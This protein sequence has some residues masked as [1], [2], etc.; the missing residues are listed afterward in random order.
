VS[1]VRL[2]VDIY[3]PD[4]LSSLLLELHHY[5]SDI[6]SHA[7]RAKAKGEASEPVEI[8]PHLAALVRGSGADE[9]DITQLE[10]LYKTLS[11]VLKTAPV[12]HLTLAAMPGRTLK[13]Q[14]TVW[15]RTQIHP[16]SMLT[17]TTRSD[18]GGGIMLHAGSHFYDYSFRA[19][20][21]ANSKRIGELAGV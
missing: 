9:K 13:R 5:I 1:E 21:L 10:A 12:M 3:S 18:M 16:N 8:S 6:R 17:F 7:L 11:E 14:L 4:Q 20:V 2:P 15:F 19:R